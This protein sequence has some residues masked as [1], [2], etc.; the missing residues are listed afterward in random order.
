M[1]KFADLIEFVCLW[2]DL[3][4]ICDYWIYGVRKLKMASKVSLVA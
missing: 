2:I 3:I 4:R 1:F